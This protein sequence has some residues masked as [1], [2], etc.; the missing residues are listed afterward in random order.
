M[1]HQLQ[2]LYAYSLMRRPSPPTIPAHSGKY[3]DPAGVKRWAGLPDALKATQSHGSKR[4]GR[5]KGAW[6]TQCVLVEQPSCSSSGLIQ[7]ALVC[8]STKYTKKLCKGHPG[9]LCVLESRCQTRSR[10]VKC[11]RKWRLE[12]HGKMPI[13]GRFLS[14]STL[15]SMSGQGSV[16]IMPS[17][18]NLEICSCSKCAW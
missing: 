2:P 10:Q 18:L 17:G 9:H 13:F 15:A 8:K 7:V 6:R 16:W 14:T 3:V 4:S 12:I 11:L 1:S 5:D